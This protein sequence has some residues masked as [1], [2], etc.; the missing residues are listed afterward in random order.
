M[1]AVAHTGGGV[2]TRHAAARTTLR[3][4]ALVVGPAVLAA[5]CVL[6]LAVV[7][8]APA[9]ADDAKARRVVQT[10]SRMIKTELYA[11]ESCFSA[12]NAPCLQGATYR[13]YR[14]VL[15]ARAKVVPLRKRTLS[16]R[17]R[18]GIERYIAAL[19]HEIAA[20]WELYES[21]LSRYIARIEQALLVIWGWVAAADRA[22]PLIDS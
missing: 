15:D 3:R 10:Q 4:T 7:P 18:S 13:L 11:A 19:D 6:A 5:V 21:A 1:R 20:S 16:P 12:R 14:V 22:M 8:A 17:V 9:A 2:A